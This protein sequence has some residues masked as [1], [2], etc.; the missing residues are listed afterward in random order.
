MKS[1][2]RLWG[3]KEAAAYLGLSVRTLQ[4][5]RSGRGPYPSIPFVKIS[6]RCVKYRRADLDAWIEE[7]V[8]GSG[9]E[10]AVVEL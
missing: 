4:N 9:N 2:E 5:W 3:E 7:R 1:E 6:A 10:N 8:A